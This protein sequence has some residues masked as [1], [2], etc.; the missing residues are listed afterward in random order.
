MMFEEPMALA[1]AFK[2]LMLNW[3]AED[4]RESMRQALAE[5]SG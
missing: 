1:M 4:K 2:G 3:I 5:V